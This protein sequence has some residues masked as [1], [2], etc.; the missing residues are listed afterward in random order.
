MPTYPFGLNPFSSS[1]HTPVPDQSQRV[2]THK[3]QNKDMQYPHQSNPDISTL[4]D[5]VNDRTTVLACFYGG[6]TITLEE[7]T[8]MIQTPK[9]RILTALSDLE[10]SQEIESTTKE[11]QPGYRKLSTWENDDEA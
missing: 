9:D 4:M 6:L 11:G 3:R 10:T 7:I 8:T 2:P 5:A 1:L